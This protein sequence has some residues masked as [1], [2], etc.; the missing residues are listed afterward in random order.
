MAALPGS[1]SV[2]GFQ[3][4]TRFLFLP[5]VASIFCRLEDCIKTRSRCNLS[6]SSGTGTTS[7]PKSELSWNDLKTLEM[8]S[9]RNGAT[10]VI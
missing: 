4:L 6:G 8:A 5:T 10:E 3:L 1:G 9:L 7:I 2:G